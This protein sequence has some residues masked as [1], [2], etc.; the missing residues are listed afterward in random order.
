MG[1]RFRF[2]ENDQKLYQVLILLIKLD[3]AETGWKP[4]LKVVNKT[5]TRLIL[6]K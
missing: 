6:Y 1:K 4:N 5:F 2:L 3:A